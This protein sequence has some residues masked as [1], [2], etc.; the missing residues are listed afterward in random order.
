[1]LYDRRAG[2][3]EPAD[4][5]NVN[6]KHIS[7]AGVCTNFG[8]IEVGDKMH[9]VSYYDADKY[10]PTAHKGD[11]H[12]HP[13]MGIAFVF[14]GPDAPSS[15]AS[16]T[17]ISSIK[18]PVIV[19]PSSAPAATTVPVVPTRMPTPAPTVPGDGHD[20]EH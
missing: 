18:P 15:T 14:V 1:M 16:P 7:D 11:E 6:A 2:W 8:R 13:V 9:I 19:S 12:L 4:S 20:H 5:H 10:P 17:T 3:R